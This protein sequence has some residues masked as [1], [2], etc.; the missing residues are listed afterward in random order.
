MIS[1]IS[2]M[3]GV[4][5]VCPGLHPAQLRIRLIRTDRIDEHSE[6]R[7]VRRTDTAVV[8]RLLQRD[9]VVFAVTKSLTKGDCVF[10]EPTPDPSLKGREVCANAMTIGGGVFEKEL[11]MLLQRT[12]AVVEIMHLHL[13]A[14]FVA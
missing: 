8:T 10:D 11:S 6:P 13:H 2:G 5:A 7:F 14:G 9:I 12:T 3:L 4:T 1:R